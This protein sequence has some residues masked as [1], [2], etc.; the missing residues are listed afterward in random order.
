M[1]SVPKLLPQIAGRGR[2]RPWLIGTYLAPPVADP[3][4]SLAVGN[5]DRM[6][7]RRRTIGLVVSAAGLSML[8]QACGSSGATSAV[9]ASPVSACSLMTGP[10]A[11]RALGEP[12]QSP[13]ECDT[14]PGNQSSGLYFPEEVANHGPLQVNVSWDKRVVSTFT[15]AH[16]GHARYV[17]TLAPPTY[18]KVTIDGVPAYWQLSPAA[19]PG[20][21]QRIE[22]MKNG[23]VV[24]LTSMGLGQPQVERA[25]AVILNRL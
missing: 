14:L 6:D 8:A 7:K 17:R 19:G 16:S 2:Y 22:S 10:D 24:D 5:T 15:V 21:A 11:S 13:K 3:G 20:N 25:L 12:V 18:A 23:Y 1:A 9:P 4:G